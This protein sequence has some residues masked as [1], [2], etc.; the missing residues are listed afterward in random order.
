MNLRKRHFYHFNAI[1]LQVLVDLD[2]LTI[3][4]EISFDFIPFQNFV[5]YYN[6]AIK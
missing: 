2:N 3:I 1:K 5:V 6:V 4:F